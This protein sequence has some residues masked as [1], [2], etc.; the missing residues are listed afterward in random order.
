[1]KK[2]FLCLIFILTASFSSAQTAN[3]FLSAA[4]SGVCDSVGLPS[5]CADNEVLMA[6]CAIRD[7]KTC[8][9][10][11]E[12]NE[13]IYSTPTA[14]ATAVLIPVKQK[15]LFERRKN[16][17]ISKLVKLVLSDPAQCVDILTAAK[18]NTI[19]CK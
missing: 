1:M 18:L 11:R 17:I 6:W 9:D 2:L 13:K 4:N 16:D 14:Y 12:P 8:V 10:T 3:D 7:A 19:I 5:G 15:E